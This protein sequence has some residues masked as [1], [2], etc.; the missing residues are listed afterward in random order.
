MRALTPT[1]SQG[2]RELTESLA[3]GE[4]VDDQPLTE[5][6]G[7]QGDGVSSLMRRVLECLRFA[8][9]VRS[10]RTRR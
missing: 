1:L 7:V 6:Q 9:E 2:E 4:G 8:F 10:R 5:G 3:G